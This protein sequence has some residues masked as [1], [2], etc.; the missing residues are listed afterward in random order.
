MFIKSW[1]NLE[2]HLSKDI[3][4]LYIEHYKKN[5]SEEPEK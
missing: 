5:T 3:E 4:G 1:L 2:I